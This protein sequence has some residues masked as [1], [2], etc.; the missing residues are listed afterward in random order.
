MP[1]WPLTA[2][3][4][5]LARRRVIR[6][7]VEAITEA[8]EPV[9][10]LAQVIA[11]RWKEGDTRADALLKLTRQLA[12]LTVVLLLIAVATLVVALATV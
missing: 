10:D 9:E 7:N 11:D 1:P 5:L 8:M 2:L 6:R 12:V 4:I 3:T